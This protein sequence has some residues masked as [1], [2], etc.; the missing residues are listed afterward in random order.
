MKQSGAKSIHTTFRMVS[1]LALAL[2][3]AVVVVYARFDFEPG[4]A[5]SQTNPAA[6]IKVS[7]VA[8]ED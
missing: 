2:T 6:V 3:S 1:V 7:A 5:I 8:R 4:A